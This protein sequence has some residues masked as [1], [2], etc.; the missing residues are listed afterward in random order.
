MLPPQK[1]V[2]I[3]IFLIITSLFFCYSVY[4]AMASE[5]LAELDN[6]AD[7]EL[8]NIRTHIPLREEHRL[9]VF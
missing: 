7:S 5:P 2:Y 8:S 6:W 3:P 4:Q 1:S 9:R